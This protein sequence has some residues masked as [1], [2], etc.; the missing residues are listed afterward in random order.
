MIRVEYFNWIRDILYR[1]P[2]NSQGQDYTCLG[3]HKILESL[4]KSLGLEVRPR[5][6]NT[7][8]KSLCI[9]QEILK[10]PHTDNLYHVYLEVMIEGRWCRIDASMDKGLRSKFPLIEW[11]GFNSTE[12]FI[13][14]PKGM[15]YSPEESNEKYAMARRGNFSDEIEF[16][17]ALNNWFDDIRR[18][19][20]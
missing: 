14:N 10:I 18:A 16:Y 17:S 1:F 20:F 2:L 12:L 4:L 8:W 3:K 6:C 15:I 13:G 7:D 11:D 19:S 9:P 5:L